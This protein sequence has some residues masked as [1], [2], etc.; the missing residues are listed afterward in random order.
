ME[1][2]HLDRLEEDK[3]AGE[4]VVRGLNYRTRHG[5]PQWE[6]RNDLIANCLRTGSGGSNV[7]RL[8]F[9]DGSS[10][11]TQKITPLEYARAMGLPKSYELP[12]ALGAAYN[13]IGDGV[14]PPV[15]RHLAR[16]IFEPLLGRASETA[17]PSASEPLHAPW[18]PQARTPAPEDFRT[19]RSPGPR[20]RESPPGRTKRRARARPPSWPA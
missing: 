9:V 20:R 11:C 4:L 8:M 1:Q 10:V 13:L 5:V 15:I 3:R 2:P 17:E 7:Q 19:S 16:Y 14:S 12:S 18:L 6:S